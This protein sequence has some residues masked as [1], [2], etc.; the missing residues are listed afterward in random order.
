MRSTASALWE[1]TTSSM[2]CTPSSSTPGCIFDD[3]SD[4]HDKPLTRKNMGRIQFFTAAQLRACRRQKATTKMGEFHGNNKENAVYQ[5]QIER[6]EHALINLM[7]TATDDKEQ[8]KAKDKIIIDQVLLITSLTQQINAANA[9]ILNIQTT[10]S[11]CSNPQGGSSQ[12]GNPTNIPSTNNKSSFHQTQTWVGGKHRKDKRGYCWTHGFLVDPT[13]HTSA[14]CRVDKQ[15][16]RHQIA[17][18]RTITM[19][20]NKYGKPKECGV[21][22]SA[23][24]IARI[25]C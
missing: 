3:C 5:G 1:K 11:S 8:M 15:K 17:A 10:R 18:T 16:P 6:A 13:M 2:R 22:W 14:N 4:W 25:Q 20:G 19:V 23:L 24:L 7:T 12:G 21:G 9:R